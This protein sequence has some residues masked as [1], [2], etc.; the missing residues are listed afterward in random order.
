MSREVLT[1]ADKNVL[2]AVVEQSCK[3]RGPDAGSRKSVVCGD[4]YYSRSLSKLARL[5]LIE[6]LADSV[7]GSGWAATRAG[8]ECWK[9]GR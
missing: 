3:V 6:Y 9:S 2:A 8:F 7:F 5:G 4:S 1:A